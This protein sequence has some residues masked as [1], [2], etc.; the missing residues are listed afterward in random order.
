MNTDSGIETAKYA[1][2]AKGGCLKD[3]RFWIA[4]P[5]SEEASVRWYAARVPLARSAK[6][7][8]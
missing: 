6:D 5:E 4:A 1:K 7:H 2:Y 3:F 8:P